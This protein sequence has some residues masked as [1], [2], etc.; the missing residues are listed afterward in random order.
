[1]VT[2][3]LETII[4]AQRGDTA[5][6]SQIVEQYQRPVYNL[7]YRMLGGSMDAEDAAQEVFIRAYKALDRYD[8]NRKFI[9]WL[10]TIAS[11]YCIDQHRK[12]KL[13]TVSV[14]SMEDYELRG[15][16]EPIEVG[17][18]KDEQAGNVQEMLKDLGEKDRAAVIYRYWYDYSYDEIAEALDLTVSAV[19]SR[20]HRS[21]KELAKIW[22]I[23]K[24]LNVTQERI[25][26]ETPAI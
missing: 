25:A 10:L 13:D 5:A 15:N 3:E 12:R 21:R 23:K 9:T 6:F 16:S 26:H 18:V 8:T 2:S 7:C 17:M 22:I 19:K 1:M 24:E 14:D 11:N 20:L 4:L